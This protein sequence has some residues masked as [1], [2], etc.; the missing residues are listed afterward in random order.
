LLAASPRWQ[1]SELTRIS[2]IICIYTPAAQ[3][4]RSK[5]SLSSGMDLAINSSMGYCHSPKYLP[6]I[7]LPVAPMLHRE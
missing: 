4:Y 2:C 3:D 6:I 5:D 1:V 7:P